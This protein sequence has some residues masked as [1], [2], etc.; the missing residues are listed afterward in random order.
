MHDTTAPAI[1]DRDFL[2]LLNKSS[3]YCHLE[4]LSFSVVGSY[5]DDR[6]RDKERKKQQQTFK[7]IDHTWKVSLKASRRKLRTLAEFDY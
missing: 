6:D 5:S 7:F 3:N 1:C 4:H 2:H